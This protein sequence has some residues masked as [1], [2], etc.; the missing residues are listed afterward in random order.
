MTSTMSSIVM[1]PI[2]RSSWSTTGI[3]IRSYLRTVSA[4]TSWSSVVWTQTNCVF[5]NWSTSVSSFA[6]SSFRSGT[7]PRSFLCGSSK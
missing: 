1:M 5:I 7:V 2:I 3:E 6:S 4:T